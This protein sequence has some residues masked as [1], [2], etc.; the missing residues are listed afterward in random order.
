MTRNRCERPRRPQMSTPSRIARIP[1]AITSRYA[2]LRREQNL[3]ARHLAVAE[4]ERG[5][6]PHA[7]CRIAVARDR[8]TP[9]VWRPPRRS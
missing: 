5:V 7:I 8:R 6:R 1:S 2:A 3:A 4:V 9:F